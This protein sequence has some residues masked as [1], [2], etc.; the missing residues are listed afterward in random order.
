MLQDR[1]RRAPLSA[2]LALSSGALLLL[3]A[4]CG[5]ARGA[6]TGAQRAMAQVSACYG[7]R[8]LGAVQAHGCDN[9]VAALEAPGRRASGA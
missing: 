9:A 4:A 7:L 6:P 5:D 1:S 2:I 3:G 8:A